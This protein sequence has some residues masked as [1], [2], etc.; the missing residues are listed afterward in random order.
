MSAAQAAPLKEQIRAATDPRDKERL[1]VVLWATSGQHTLADL[2]RLAGR[3]R[4]TIQVWLDDYT[5]GGR[6]Q[7]LER[8][9]PPRT[10]R[11]STPRAAIG[12][13]ACWGWSAKWTS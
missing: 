13:G 3:V 11:V 4:S 6:S 9:K 12:S 7:R 8:V 2:A 1:Q 10:R 5:A